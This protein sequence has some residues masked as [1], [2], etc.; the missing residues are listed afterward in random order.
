[1]QNLSALVWLAT[2]M[3]SLTLLAALCAVVCW[4]R[5][6]ELTSLATRNR[7]AINSVEHF[8]SRI[9][10]LHKR[11]TSLSKKFHLEERRDPET[12]K[13]RTARDELPEDPYERKV[14]LRRQHGLAGMGHAD[15]ARRA[16]RAEG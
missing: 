15:I 6:S 4:R 13:S 2:I 10:E 14:A 12:G 8:E 3:G 11:I 1:M 5:A 16:T 7:E 9:D